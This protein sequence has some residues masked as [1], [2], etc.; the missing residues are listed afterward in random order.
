[1]VT[2]GVSI[3]STWY[4]R[5]LSYKMVRIE[6]NTYLTYLTHSTSGVSRMSNL[7]IYKSLITPL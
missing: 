5:S 1:M 7:D 6:L 3:T 2:S 4:E